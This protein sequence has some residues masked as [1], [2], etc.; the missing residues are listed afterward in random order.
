MKGSGVHHGHVAIVIRKRRVL[1]GSVG[2]H[3]KLAGIVHVED[4]LPFDLEVDE[5]CGHVEREIR[6]KMCPYIIISHT[7]YTYSY[8]V[9]DHT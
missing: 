1:A 2:G 4:G 6:W 3:G 9:W 8:I 7:Q 5:I